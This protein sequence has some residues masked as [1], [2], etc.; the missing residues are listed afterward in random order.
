MKIIGA[1]GQGLSLKPL[2]P[3]IRDAVI[4]G[5]SQL[6][7][8]G[9]SGDVE[10]SVEPNGALWKH[11]PVGKD[12]SLVEGSVVVAVLQSQ[13]AMRLFL[14]LFLH[15]V[16]GSGRLGDIEEALFVEGPYDGA[17]DQRRSSR[18]LQLKA[19]RHLDQ[20]LEGMGFSQEQPN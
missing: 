2:L 15:L 1:A 7:D 13:N 14:E 18:E 11:H 16:V 4:I 12:D 5:I 3:S 9:R 8:T 17:L 20:I 19:L 10:R 6:P